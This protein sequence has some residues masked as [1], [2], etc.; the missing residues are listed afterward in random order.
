MTCYT[1]WAGRNGSRDREVC[2]NSQQFQRIQL[3]FT[4]IPQLRPPVDWVR[5][6]ADPVA[7][8]YDFPFEIV[9]CRGV[10]H[11]AHRQ[12]KAHG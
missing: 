3:R 10:E 2:R 5:D 12:T 11:E 6:L 9:I 7:G 8:D 4:R 1:A